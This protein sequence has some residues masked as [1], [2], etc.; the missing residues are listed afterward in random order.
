MR[1]GYIPPPL[2]LLWPLASPLLLIVSFWWRCLGPANGKRR[3]GARL[4]DRDEFR[5]PF[6]GLRAVL[7]IDTMSEGCG[8]ASDYSHHNCEARCPRP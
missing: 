8:S 3:F 4:L 7:P 6:G 5:V 2:C 1:S